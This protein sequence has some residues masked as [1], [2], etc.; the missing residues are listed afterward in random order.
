GLVTRF[1]SPCRRGG[2]V[3]PPRGPT[4][5]LV[6]NSKVC[7]IG[8]GD[9]KAEWRGPTSACGQPMGVACHERAHVSESAPRLYANHAV[10]V[11][12]KHQS[13]SHRWQELPRDVPPGSTP[14]AARTVAHASGAARLPSIAP[15]PADDTSTSRRTPIDGCLHFLAETS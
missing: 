14:N 6:S 12:L 2:R 15:T 9:C 11:I 3:C 5:Y 13:R 1:S 10:G 4:S 8:D 7:V